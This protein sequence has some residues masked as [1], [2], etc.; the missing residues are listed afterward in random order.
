MHKKVYIIYFTPYYLIEYFLSNFMQH[1]IYIYIYIISVSNYRTIEL[2]V[3]V[4]FKLY[5]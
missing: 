5:E 3:T 2:V 4:E 1:Y